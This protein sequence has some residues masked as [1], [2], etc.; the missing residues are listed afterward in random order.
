V[1]EGDF[2]LRAVVVLRSVHTVVEKLTRLSEETTF[3]TS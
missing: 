3:E 2:W 1:V